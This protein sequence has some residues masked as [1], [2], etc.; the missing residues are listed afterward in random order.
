MKTIKTYE[1]FINERRNDFMAQ[2]L[3]ELASELSKHGMKCVGHLGSVTVYDSEEKDPGRTFGKSICRFGDNG[4]IKWD[5]SFIERL[6][7][8]N[9]K[10]ELIK[11]FAM[12]KKMDS[13]FD[14]QPV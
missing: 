4:N 1:T 13:S 6:K 10:K 2:R 7:L 8:P 9:I 11:K 5:L 3:I 14:Y 12:L